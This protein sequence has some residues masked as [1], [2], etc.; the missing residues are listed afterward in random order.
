MGFLRTIYL[1]EV[2]NGELNLDFKV[3]LKN[4]EVL[5]FE[6]KNKMKKYKERTP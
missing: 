1:S 6:T 5:V 4:S 2:K 3:W